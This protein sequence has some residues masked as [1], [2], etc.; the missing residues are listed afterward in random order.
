MLQPY[1][2]LLGLLEISGISSFDLQ[3]KFFWLM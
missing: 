1:L 2:S 3:E